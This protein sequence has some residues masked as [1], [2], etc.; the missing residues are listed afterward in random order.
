M[1]VLPGIV[2]LMHAPNDNLASQDLSSGA[3]S[4]VL[5]YNWMFGRDF[6]I[7]FFFFPLALGVLCFALSQS[8]AIS[9]SAFW[10]FL[11]L[12]AFGAGPF[13]FGPTWFAY[14][15]KKN[16]QYWKS[17]RSKQI[18]F[19]L[20]P[21]LIILIT[22]LTFMY[23]FGVVELL[24]TIW[25]IQH[26]IQQN[27][28]ILLLYHN[29]S[30]GEAIVPRQIE[31]RSLQ[32]PSILFSTIFFWR[33][34][35]VA[36]TG[37]GWIIFFALASLVA[38][39]PVFCY[40]VELRKQVAAGATLNVPALVFWG[41]SIGSF[42]PFAFVGKSF[43]EAWIIPVTIHWFQYI[44]LNYAMVKKKYAVGSP[45]VSDMPERIP[46][47]TL[48]FATCI[49]LF[50]MAFLIVFVGGELCKSNNLFAKMC[51]GIWLGIT[52]C[53]YFL[54]AFLWRFRE[55]HARQSILP[56]LLTYRKVVAKT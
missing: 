5:A 11:V 9:T 10:M 43:A 6:D 44:G 18:V 56:H 37:I 20:M 12:D 7:F 17:L 2:T 54:D 27:V 8:T 3:R 13:H 14:Y 46:P 38:A 21:P 35:L 16:L 4:T 41:L 25:A 22:T 1:H 45:L 36:P 15:D 30:T 29:Q 42:I 51:I 33:I 32:F 52:A 50:V 31:M 48:F 23:V 19:F 55:A 34:F 40:V 49:L 39:Y 24:I 47:L 26:I 53:H 28:G